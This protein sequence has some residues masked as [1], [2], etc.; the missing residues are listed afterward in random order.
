MI[1]KHKCIDCK[2]CD[3]ANRLCI[4]KEGDKVLIHNLYPDDFVKSYR[5]D[6]FVPLWKANRRQYKQMKF[7]F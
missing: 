2:N 1:E 6:Y 4:V 7:T 5:C 3:P